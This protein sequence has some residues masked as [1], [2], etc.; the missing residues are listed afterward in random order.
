M[1]SQGINPISLK[2]P[3]RLQWRRLLVSTLLLP[4]GLLLPTS[5]RA[6]TTVADFA[7]FGSASCLIGYEAEITDSANPGGL[8]SL[9]VGG[10]GLV[11]V[12]LG[13]T[14]GGVRAGNTLQIGKGAGAGIALVLG[15]AI[16]NNE[17]ELTQGARVQG[18]VDGG[19]SIL[20]GQNAEVTG[21]VTSA[22]DITVDPAGTVGGSVNPFSTPLSVPNIA[23]P[24]VNTISPGPTAVGNGTSGQSVAPAPGAWGAL[25]VGTSSQVTL[26]AGEYHFSTIDIGQNSTLVLNVVAGQEI[27]I[28]VAGDVNFANALTVRIGDGTGD[29]NARRK[30]TGPLVYLETHGRFLLQ[31]NGQWVGAAF[32]P[33]DEVVFGLSSHIWGAGYGV[34]VEL[35]QGCLLDFTGPERFT[36][37]GAL[38]PLI[39][40]ALYAEDD[41]A[42]GRDVMVDFAAPIG[43]NDDVKVKQGGQTGSVRA[44]GKLFTGLEATIHGSQI[45]NRR[46][47]VRDSSSV[48][49]SVDG[50]TTSGRV[51]LGPEST[52]DGV[53]NSGGSVLQQV[54]ASVTCGSPPCIF[55]N[56]ADTAV[57]SLLDLETVIG[58]STDVAATLAGTPARVAV[59]RP[60][61]T[62][63]ILAPGVYGSMNLGTGNQLALAS[64]DYFFDSIR[65]GR[66]L[67]L[68]LNLSGGEIAIFV[69]SDAIFGRGLTIDLAGGDATDIYLEAHGRR[70]L[71]SSDGEWVGTIWAVNGNIS[72]GRGTSVTGAA[73]AG[74]DIQ[75]KRDNS[76]TFALADRLYLTGSPSGAF[77]DGLEAAAY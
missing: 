7:A 12:R 72:F 44:G 17:I 68:K 4:I 62:S 9:L 45:G 54:G 8:A 42:V 51:I 50:G 66:D 15:D 21:N 14:I 46:V 77:L 71:L 2:P 52:V 74:K 58:P 31:Q 55:E 43:A 18:N 69:G 25:R 35:R 76:V 63:T 20:V 32:A 29:Q 59:D 5:A 10:M 19:S 60:P 28:F 33:F 34:Q 24:A 27:A 57:H 11:D 36:G 73:F 48:L 3:G 53:V 64:G 56:S 1:L 70:V 6:T 61:G 13:A 67:V 16:G 30:A 26:S 40:F 47:Y 41:V 22:A 49:G 38:F 37:P 23:L 65:A 75:L 39:D